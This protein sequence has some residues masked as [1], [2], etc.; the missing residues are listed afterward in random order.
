MASSLEFLGFPLLFEPANCLQAILV[1]V[2]H[3]T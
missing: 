3:K 2:G 1:L